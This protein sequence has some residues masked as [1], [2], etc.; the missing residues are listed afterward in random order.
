MTALQWFSGLTAFMLF[1]VAMW[2]MALCRRPHFGIEN[3]AEWI[4]YGVIHLA[5]AMYGAGR[6]VTALSGERQ[7]PWIDAIGIA[8]IAIALTM[9]RKRTWP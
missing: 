3:F 8:V 7:Y 2:R 9:A 4:V 1:S 6:L 5:A